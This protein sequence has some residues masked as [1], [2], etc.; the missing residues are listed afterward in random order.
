MN[1][2]KFCSGC[3]QEKS[4]TEFGVSKGIVSSRCRQCAREYASDYRQ[5]G[6]QKKRTRLELLRTGLKKCSHCHEIKPATHEHFGIDRNNTTDLMT[7]WCRDCLR[8]LAREAA[9]KRQKPTR[10]RTPVPPIKQREYQR[11]WKSKEGNRLLANAR[12]MDWQ[13][14]NPEKKR[15]QRE[16]RRAR[17]IGAV[18][19]YFSEHVTWHW[20]VQDGKCAY[21]N[22]Q[23]N[24]DEFHVDHILPLTRGG[25]NWTQNLSLACPRCNLS[26]SNKLPEEWLDRW[27]FY[28]PSS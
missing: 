11:R 23:L 4:L 24:K 9:P 3:E 14:R 15:V 16:N 2:S 25:S 26:K 8:Q 19:Y 1:T 20:L 6:P 17:E 21:C 18:G 22:C 10:R 13:K 12:A 5:N 7:S 28:E 27:Y